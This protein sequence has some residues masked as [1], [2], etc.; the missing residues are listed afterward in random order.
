MQYLVIGYG[1]SGKSAAKFLTERGNSVSV[2]DDQIEGE[3]P[4]LD[5]CDRVVLSPG[6][7]LSHR[8]VQEALRRGIEVIGE[9]ELGL[10][11]LEG[12][13]VG[14]TGTNGKTTT[15]LLVTH[16]LNTCGLKA[17]ALGNVGTPITS[18]GEGIAVVELSSYQLETMSVRVFDA[19]AITNITPDHLDRYGTF[20]RYRAAKLR[21][22]ECAKGPCYEGDDVAFSLCTHFGVTR[23]QFDRACET[24]K[25]PAHR[26]EVIGCVDGITYINDSKATNV[27]S[28]IYAISQVLG[29]IVLIA[30]G[31]DKGSSYA[32]WLKAFQNRVEKVCLLGEAKTRIRGALAGVISMEDY[33]S[34]EEAVEGA[35]VA[36]RAGGTILLS[37]GCSSFDMFSN[38]EARGE[39]FRKLVGG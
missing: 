23:E 6:V 33:S 2:F 1:V 24:F 27:E 26:L 30:G 5:S 19:V 36:C 32:P 8:L 28:V 12:P 9:A 34:L 18:G 15:T 17:Q 31:R 35:R 4:D 38:F 20:E 11:Y 39:A 29:P 25:R 3:A 14:I 10:R 13:A 21:I 22:R 16:V 37:P 7:A